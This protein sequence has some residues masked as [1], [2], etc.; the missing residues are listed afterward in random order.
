MRFLVA[1]TMPPGFSRKEAIEIQKASQK[2]P[3]IRGYR[4]FVNLTAG[5][6][7]CIY[8]APTREQLVDYLEK[9]EMPFDYIVQVEMEGEGASLEDVPALVGVRL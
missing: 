4:S 2:D 8:D 1:H 6:A 9:S 3:V 7:F 5:K